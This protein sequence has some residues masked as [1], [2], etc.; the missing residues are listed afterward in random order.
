[1]INQAEALD[2]AKLI[3]ETQDLE[4]REPVYAEKQK[5]G[6]FSFFKRREKYWHIYTN[7]VSRENIIRITLD[8]S[9]GKLI[10]QRL[11]SRIKAS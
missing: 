9:N 2:M 10:D 11:I 8:A 3:A 6:A 5:K 1:M 4:W 7:V